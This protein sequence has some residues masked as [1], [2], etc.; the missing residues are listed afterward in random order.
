MENREQNFGELMQDYK[1]NMKKPDTK[2]RSERD[3]YIGKFLAELNPDRE[4]NGYKP[5]TAKMFIMKVY[6]AFNNSDTGVLYLLWKKCEQF[7]N[8]SKGFHYLTRK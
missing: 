8:F 5:Y 3:E 1:S 6:N 4:K 7:D 2:I